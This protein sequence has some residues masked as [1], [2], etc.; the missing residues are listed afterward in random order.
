M[1]VLVLDVLDK[2]H[3][4]CGNP[5]PLVIIPADEMMMFK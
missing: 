3:F 1:T 4:S 5:I 2:F